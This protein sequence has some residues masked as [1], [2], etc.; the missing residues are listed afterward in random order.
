MS[1]KEVLQLLESLEGILSDTPKPICET[2]PLK[3]SGYKPDTQAAI[4]DNLYTYFKDYKF[5][6]DVKRIGER[7]QFRI[8]ENKLDWLANWQTH[9]KALQN[10]KLR[11]FVYNDSDGYL[12][13]IQ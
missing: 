12:I 10:G 8:A 1:I 9:S 11:L 5:L 6:K 4:L 3:L 2:N 7:L 13:E